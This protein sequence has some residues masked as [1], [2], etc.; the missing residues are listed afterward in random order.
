MTVLCFCRIHC[1][2]HLYKLD[3]SRD[4][5]DVV[6]G[7]FFFAVI[8]NLLAI[9][10]GQF[11]LVSF[12]ITLCDFKLLLSSFLTCVR[13]HSK[14]QIIDYIKICLAVP[15]ESWLIGYSTV[16]LVP[17]RNCTATISLLHTTDTC[18]FLE[19]C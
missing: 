7:L 18:F 17:V 15:S 19:Y 3:S 11:L 2:K 4:M 1:P 9:I 12:D 13:P 8:A 5:S 6:M 14:R 16:R 10:K